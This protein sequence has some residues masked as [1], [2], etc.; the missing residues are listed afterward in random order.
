VLSCSLARLPFAATIL[1][2]LMEPTPFRLESPATKIPEPLLATERSDPHDD[3]LKRRALE[4]T[5]R[6]SSERTRPKRLVPMAKETNDLREAK[7]KRLSE[8]SAKV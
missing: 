8:D 6:A 3:W 2:W 4:E 5:L 1:I 7:Q